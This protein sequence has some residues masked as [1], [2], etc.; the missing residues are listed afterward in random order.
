MPEEVKT[1]IALAP[2]KN[3]HTELQIMFH[4]TERSET[5]KCSYQCLYPILFLHLLP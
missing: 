3:Y 4:V 5:G 2:A 1:Q